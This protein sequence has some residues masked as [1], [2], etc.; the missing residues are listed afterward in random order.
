MQ[1]RIQVVDTG[2]DT[3]GGCSSEMRTVTREGKQKS[4][5][6]IDASLTAD[7]RCKEESYVN[8]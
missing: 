1:V 6:S 8:T 4:V 5:T 3:G 2:V 7:F